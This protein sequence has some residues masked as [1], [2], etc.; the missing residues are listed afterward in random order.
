M[1]LESDNPSPEARASMARLFCRKNSKFRNTSI[2]IENSR[3]YCCISYAAKDWRLQRPP[4][5]ARRGQ[6][7]RIEG[8]GHAPY[9]HRED[10]RH[11]PFE[12][13][14]GAVTSIVTSAVPRKMG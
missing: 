8:A 14:Q 7:A 6:G 5:F 9:R 12:R 11:R 2:D 4:G 13:L 1:L 3:G 10:A